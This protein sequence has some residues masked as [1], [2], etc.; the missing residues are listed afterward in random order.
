MVLGPLEGRGAL[1][2]QIDEVALARRLSVP[3]AVLQPAV[4]VING[5]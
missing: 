4:S 1:V 2:V 5:N 3:D